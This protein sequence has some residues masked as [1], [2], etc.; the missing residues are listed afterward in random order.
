MQDKISCNKINEIREERIA[1]SIY[2]GSV[3]SR[4]YA[5]FLSNPLDIFHYLYKFFTAFDHT[6]GF[7]TLLFNILTIQ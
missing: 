2:T 5:Q 1:N 4:A 6:L 7:L 3:I